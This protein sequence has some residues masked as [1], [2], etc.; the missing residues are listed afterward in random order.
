[1]MRLLNNKANVKT[2]SIIV[3]VLFILGV[4][5]L[6][7]TQMASPAMSAGVSN[8]GVVD[9]NRVMTPDSPVLAKAS[10][11]MQAYTKQLDEEFASKSPSL[12]DQGKQKLMDE[13]REKALEKR[14]EIQ[15]GVNKQIADAAKSVG[16]AKGLTAV[17]DHNAVLF[18]GVDITEQVAKKLAGKADK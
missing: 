14:K 15:E 10:E 18:G 3:A 9:M 1:M 8:I 6:A 7:Y 5:A 16:D 11:E 17:L 12:D 2:V 13:L 4:G